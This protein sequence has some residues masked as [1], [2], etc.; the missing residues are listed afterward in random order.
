LVEL[1][2]AQLVKDVYRVLAV[3]E[4][5]QLFE[6]T[7]GQMLTE[8]LTIEQIALG[9]IKMNMG[10]TVKELKEQDFG[11]EYG[12][13]R[14]GSRDGGRD[15]GRGDRFGRGERSGSDRFGRGERESGSRFE[16]GGERS[17][18]FSDRREGGDRFAPRGESGPR[19]FE[20]R[21]P[22]E[23]RTRDANMTRLFL[24]LGNKD[25]IRPNDIVGAIA[26]ETGVPG[27]SI[28]GIDIFDNFSFVDVP[29]KDAEHVIK[30]MKN[31]TIKGKSVNM[32]ISKG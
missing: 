5:N 25:R 16:R 17:G 8:G 24:N 11:I 21:A 18:R 19:D 26:G 30:V 3:E 22:R 6:A 7:I 28:G 9:L 15:G 32:E 14:E 1:K 27:K 20:R 2:K 12:V 10:E 13:R 4:D 31:N 29:Q 23:E